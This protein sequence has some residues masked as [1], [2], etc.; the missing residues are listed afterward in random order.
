M[1]SVSPGRPI[2]NGGLARYQHLN[3]R[4][5]VAWKPGQLAV[6][7]SLRHDLASVDVPSA[8]G[9]WASEHIRAR[10]LAFRHLS[11]NQR[12]SHVAISLD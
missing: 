5:L 3:T 1:P 11:R 7:L 12:N 2:Q 4:A 6:L 9:Q 10:N 8:D